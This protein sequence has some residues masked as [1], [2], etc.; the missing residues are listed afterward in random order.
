MPVMRQFGLFFKRAF[1]CSADSHADRNMV[2]RGSMSQ[3]LEHPE[4]WLLRRF[5]ER[6]SYL[7]N[8]SFRL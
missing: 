6:Y 3:L 5:R 4:P 7:R 8:S 1:Q 2:H